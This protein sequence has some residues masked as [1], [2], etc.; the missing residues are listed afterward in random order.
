MKKTIP[1]LLL[2]LSLS[3]AA[4]AQKLQKNASFLKENFSSLFDSSIRK[5]A[6]DKWK[7]D[8]TMVYNEINKQ[9]DALA[10]ILVKFKPSNSNILYKSI[11]KSSIKE[12]SLSNEIK[13]NSIKIIGFGELLALECDWTI[14]QKEYDIKLKEKFKK[15]KIASIVAIPIVIFLFI[16]TSK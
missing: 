5:T 12:K 15:I 3:N 2:V 11:I 6:I 10:D 14:V 1:V 8:S 13:W 9:S 4:Y 16:L 7:E